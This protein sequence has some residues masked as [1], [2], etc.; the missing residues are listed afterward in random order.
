MAW[1]YWMVGGWFVLWIAI[2]VRGAFSKK[3]N[4]GSYFDHYQGGRQ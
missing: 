4:S 1:L 3:T 2:G